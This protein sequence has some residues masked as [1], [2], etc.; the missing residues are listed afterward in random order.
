MSNFWEYLSETP[1]QRG[2]MACVLFGFANGFM[3]GFVVM[4]K[5]ALKMGTL[6]HGLLPGIA[7]AVLFMGLT[8]WTALAGAIVAALFIGLGSIFMSRTSRLD[9]DTSMAIL[10]TSAFAGGYILLTNLNMTQKLSDWLF[11]SITGM[12]DADLW[13]AFG[14]AVTAVLTLTVLQ[15]PLLIYLFEPNVAASL[16]VPV[17]A[18]NYALFG[19]MILMLLSSLQAVGCILS[20]GLM[21]TPGATVYLCSDNTRTIFLGGGILGA[22]GAT[23]AFFLSYVLSWN[24]GSTIVLVLGV[25]FAVAYIFSPKYGLFAKH[26]QVVH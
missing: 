4:R 14:I 1:A 10:Y 24:I 18:L 25:M 26:R 17:R 7:L 11:G 8:Q 5:S 19:V 12:S 15:R 16:G 2:L 21:V 6:S 3:S 20:L 9:Q 23:G 13:I 22:L